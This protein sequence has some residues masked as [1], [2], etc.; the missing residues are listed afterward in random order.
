MNPVFEKINE[1]KQKFD[2]ALI[3]SLQDEE[4][5]NVCCFKLIV[6]ERKFDVEINISK[7]RGF[8]VRIDSDFLYTPKN[9]NI[10]Y[11]HR[12]EVAIQWYGIGYLDIVASDRNDLVKS[13]IAYNTICNYIL[14]VL[15]SIE[16]KQ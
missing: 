5:I 12:D 13:A 8:E 9:F 2:Y 16:I 4:S 15:T 11:D 14:E 1:N 6:N 7:N 3:E 10:L